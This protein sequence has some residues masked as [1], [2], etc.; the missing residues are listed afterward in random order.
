MFA[1]LNNTHLFIIRWRIM[2]CRIDRFQPWR[3]LRRRFTRKT[4]GNMNVGRGYSRLLLRTDRRAAG[5]RH[6]R[7][8]WHYRWGRESIGIHRF[9]RDNSR[10]SCGKIHSWQVF[11]WFFFLVFSGISEAAGFA[12][13]IDPRVHFLLCIHGQKVNAWTGV[14]AEHVVVVAFAVD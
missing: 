5:R 10:R 13:H 2:T 8:H 4:L 14:N 7:R 9:W 3:R 6:R 1:T 11:R 12:H